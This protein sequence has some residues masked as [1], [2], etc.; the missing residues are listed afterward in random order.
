MRHALLTLCILVCGCANCNQINNP[1]STDYPCGTRAHACS[2]TPLAC[3]WNSEVCGGAV[4]S[5]CP[6]DSC[7]Y[8]GDN[9]G[10][11]KDAGPAETPP[12]TK[13]WKP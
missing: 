7:C 9:F 5:G 13:Q 4:G 2:T 11:S 6:T 3:C 10:A 1:V 8:G 12:P